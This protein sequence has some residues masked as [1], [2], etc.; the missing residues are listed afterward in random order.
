[1]NHIKKIDEYVNYAD[2]MVNK[3]P[4]ELIDSDGPREILD[5]LKP[6][7]RAVIDDIIESTSNGDEDNTEDILRG[8]NTEELRV[9]QNTIDAL[10]NS[11]E[12]MLRK[13][14]S[15]N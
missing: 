8:F 15:Q 9:I 14:V 11:V 3:L 7:L 6:K 4:K 12:N 2:D 10:N 1:M 13:M 5:R